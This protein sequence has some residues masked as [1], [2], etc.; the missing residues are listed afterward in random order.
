[1][2]VDQVDD[3]ERLLRQ[4]RRSHRVPPDGGVTDSCLDAETLAAWVDGGLSGA[5][6]E[7]VQ[8]HVADCARCQAFVGTLARVS[9][10]ASETPGRAARPWTLWNCRRR[11]SGSCLSPRPR[12]PS[13]C[14]SP[15]L[16]T[17]STDPPRRPTL[18]TL[19]TLST[20][21][22]P[23][24][25]KSSDNAESK[26]SE[27]ARLDSPPTSLNRRWASAR[28]ASVAH[29]RA[30][31]RDKQRRDERCREEQRCEG[32][33]FGQT[34]GSEPEEGRAGAG[35]FRRASCGG[36]ADCSG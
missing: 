15:F 35:G 19:S 36:P 8:V 7:T 31:P 6:L 25:R 1:M 12:R 9:G 34:R 2:N 32:R 22:G 21:S 18:S 17:G 28:R 5:A 3:I 16:V 14:G 30:G 33:Q 20:S 26:T 24:R 13:R 23:R 10:A 29:R 4:S 27:P 11:S